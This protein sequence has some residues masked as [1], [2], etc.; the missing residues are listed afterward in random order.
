MPAKHKIRAV[1]FENGD[2]W[3]AQCLEH[4]IATQARTLDE[5]LYELERILVAHMV[6]AGAAPFATIPKAPQA[7]WQMYEAAVTRVSSVKRAQLP[8]PVTKRPILEVRKA[9]A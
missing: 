9:A 1:A 8:I 2:H 5:L 6:G 7:F 4:D 3:V